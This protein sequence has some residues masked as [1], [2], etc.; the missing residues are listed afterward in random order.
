VAV[1]GDS[2]FFHAGMPGL[3]NIAYNPAKVCVVILD[4]QVVAMTGHQPTPETGRRVT[5]EEAKI[6]GI[7]GIGTSI[8]SPVF[9][10]K[11]SFISH[12]PVAGEK[13]GG[14]KIQT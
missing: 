10:G 2:T 5:G 12:M 7:E 11:E 14:I 3:L 4:N 8:Q 13:I 1:I 6:I 9:L